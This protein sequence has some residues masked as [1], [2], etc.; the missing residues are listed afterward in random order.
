M[1]DDHVIE[2]L[3]LQNP[4]SFV[5]PP[6]QAEIRFAWAQVS[7]RMIVL[8]GL[9]SYVI[10]RAGRSRPVNLGL[11]RIN[12][13]LHIIPCAFLCTLQFAG[14]DCFSAVI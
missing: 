8:C 2:Q 14:Q 3:D 7:R 5:E 11:V 4:G 1:A 13:S 10:R 12:Q 6:S 9:D